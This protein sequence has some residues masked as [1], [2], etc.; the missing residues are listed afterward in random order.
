MSTID[1]LAL[2]TATIYNLSSTFLFSLNIG[3][4]TSKKAIFITSVIFRSLRN[5]FKAYCIFQWG[6][7]P[8]APFHKTALKALKMT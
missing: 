2:Y 7:L 8:A 4:K 6:H 3:P 5:D 1:L